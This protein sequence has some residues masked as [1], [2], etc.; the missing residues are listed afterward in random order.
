MSSSYKVGE[1]SNYTATVQIAN[2]LPASFH[3]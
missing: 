3:I 2:A 1:I